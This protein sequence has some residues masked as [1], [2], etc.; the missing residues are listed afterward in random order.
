MASIGEVIREYR[1][2]HGLSLREFA[3]KVKLSHAYIDKLENGVDPVT[4][5]SPLHCVP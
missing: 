3:Q 5:K 1:E 4:G 2:K